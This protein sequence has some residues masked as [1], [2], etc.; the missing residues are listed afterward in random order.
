M[1]RREIGY[2]ME[3]RDAQ[4]LTSGKGCELLRK[5]E[6][7]IAEGCLAHTA[8]RRLR[9]NASAEEAR[10]AWE[11]ANLRRRAVAKLGL[12]AA[13]LFF[14]RD[15]LEMASSALVSRYHAQRFAAAGARR[16]LDL[17]GG[18]GMD[19]LAFARAGLSVAMC[20]RDPVRAVFAQANA[21]ALGLGDRIEVVCA[22]VAQA[23]LPTA[24]AAFLDP[25]RRAGSRRWTASLDDLDPPLSFVRELQ[26]RGIGTIGLKLSP[27]APHE[28]AEEY[29]G[30]IEFLSDHGECKEAF[31]ALGRLRTGQRFSAARLCEQDGRLSVERIGGDPSKGCEIGPPSGRFLYEPDPAV[32]RAHLVGTLAAELDAW[33]FEPSIAYLLSDG[34]QPTAFARAF[35]IEES[36]P[37]SRKAVQDAL[38]RRR[39]GRLVV[40]KR[41][42]P[43]EPEVVL[44]DLKLAGDRDAVLILSRCGKRHWAF[45]AARVRDGAA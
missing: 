14:D 3:M 39:I 35:E 7:Q 2:R 15:G 37:Y 6:D 29:A 36:L 31:L 21:A 28:P 5:A 32:I 4:F 18:V 13:K 27:A 8:L 16:I 45:I 33:Q 1:S 19:S 34:L 23:R 12:D 10:A 17:G 41:G 11:L 20:E 40:K 24:D 26:A 25:A 42:F 22:D 38:R 30:E 44:R 9:A 43:Q